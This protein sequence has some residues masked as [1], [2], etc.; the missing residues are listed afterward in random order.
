MN[1][2]I[3]KIQVSAVLISLNEQANIKR[4]INS[5]TWA[6]DIVVYDS[7]S[8]DNTCDIARKLGANVV[9]RPWLGFKK[10]QT[11]C[12]QQYGQSWRLV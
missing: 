6:D 12:R 11:N 5:V 1:N 10:Q 8:T 3:Q 2:N 7:G 4:A 9:A